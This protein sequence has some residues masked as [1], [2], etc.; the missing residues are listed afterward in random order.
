MELVDRGGTG[1]DRAAACSQQRSQHGGVAVFGH[2][3]AVAGKGG[4]SCGVGVQRV[5]FAFATA[6]GP[7]GAID[8]GHLDLCSLQH[9]GQTRSHN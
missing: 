6:C 4:A 8:L 7:V 3:Q 2:C 5:G 1:L 9:P